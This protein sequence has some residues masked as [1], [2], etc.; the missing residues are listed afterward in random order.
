MTPVFIALG[1]NI[2]PRLKYLTSAMAQLQ[3]LGTVL[4]IAPLYRSGPFGIEDQPDFLNSACILSTNFLPLDFLKALKDIEKNLGRRKTFRWGPREI[5]L[6]IIFFGD[7]I[8][9]QEEL[10]IPHPGFK[11][12]R[13]VLLPLVQMDAD[14]IPP[15][16][17]R[18][19]KEILHG[20]SDE[21]TL[22]LEKKNWYPS[23]K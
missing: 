20:C 11:E 13:F 10:I 21:T 18:T 17:N 12:R 15:A 19:L 4:K 1:S 2:E 14:F 3:K 6:D 7:R 8:I 16:E 9:N 5:D 22:K 23:W